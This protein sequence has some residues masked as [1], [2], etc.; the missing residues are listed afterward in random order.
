[1]SRWFNFLF[2]ALMSA[3]LL[4]GCTA[5]HYRKSADKEAYRALRVKGAS[6]TN[7]DTNFTL[8]Q[9]NTLALQSLPASTNAPD[10]LGP[11]GARELGAHILSL[12]DALLV[13]VRSSRRYQ[14]EKENLYISALGL[15]LSRHAFAPIFSASAEVAHEVDY[16]TGREAPVSDPA[17]TNAFFV[18]SSGYDRPITDAGG[19][20]GVSWLI[21]DIGRITADFTSDALRLVVGDR[22]VATSSSLTVRFTRPL[23]RNAAFKAQMESLTQAERDLLYDIRSFVQFRKDFSVEIARDYYAVLGDRDR[24][25]NSYLNL[26]SSK[27]NAERSRALAQEG[28]NTQSELGRLEQQE[29]SAEGSWI[30]AVRNYQQALD[31]FKLSLGLSISSNIV[32]DDGELEAL[33]ILDPAI[34]VDESIQVALAARMD[35]LNAKDAYEDSIRKVGLAENFLL[36][37]L[38]F[39]AGVGLRS[40]PAS[41]GLIVP[42]DPSRYSWDAGL[43]LDPGLDRKGERNSYRQAIISRNRAAR[44]IEQ[45]EDTIRLQVRNSWRTLDQAKRSY[46]IS[47]IGVRLAERRVEEQEILAELGRSKAQDQVDAQNALIDSKNERT[48]AIVAHTLSRLEFWNRLGILFIKENGRWE[49]TKDVET[50]SNR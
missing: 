6:V 19:N 39:S 45:V 3:F 27:K 40:D 36:P 12:E 18:K 21:R 1:M 4:G 14:T 43:S 35:Y 47:E 38:D 42:P 10:F 30:N 16:L 20:I 9:T 7:M 50:A 44:Q 48:Q 29:I 22:S 13:A 25:R 28:R 33:R 17:T 8:E 5:K 24:A 23:L 41:A 46:Q 32:L 37:Q 15:T 49:E 31:N 26:Q 2:V 11:E 34:T